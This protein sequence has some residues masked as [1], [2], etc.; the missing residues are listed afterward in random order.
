M[1]VSASS[2][3]SLR[4]TRAGIDT[5][6]QPIAYMHRD[7]E[8]CR[9]EGFVAMT[10]VRIQVGDRFLTATLNVVVNEQIALDEV[11]LSEAAW[12][13]LEPDVDARATVRHPAPAASAGAL[14]AKVF[15][16]RLDDAQ[17][18]TLVEDVV[19]SRLSD[20]ELAAFVSASAGERLDHGETTGLTRAMISV[21]Q[22]LDWGEGTVLDK[23]CVG[24]LPGNRTTPIVV[25]IIA[26]L[27]YLIPKTSSRA[28]TSPAGTADTMEVMA[29]VSLDIPAMRR[30]VE[31]EGGCIVW[32]GN[33]RLSP[34]DDV[35]IRIQRPLDFDSDG[36]LVASVLSKKVAAGS[37]HVLIDMPVGPTA[38]VR[39]DSSADSLAARLRH[40]AEA[41]GLQLGIYRS[42]GTQ[43]VGVG[44]GPALEARDV[45]K[46]LNNDAD[47][48][49]DL[50]ERA[51]A[52][53]G[54]LLELAPGSASGTGI[55]RARAVL[56]SRQAL[57]KFLAICEAQGGFREPPQ[58]ALTA[59][60]AAP[61]E[62]RITAIDNRRLARIAKLAG[63]PTSPAAGLETALRVGNTVQHGQP[64]FTV[65]AQSRGELAYALE[66]ARINQPFSI[67]TEGA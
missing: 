20:L 13:I 36:Q 47:A 33:V 35:L 6:Q 19:E 45:L 64:L 56:H 18:L 27:G 42:D 21:G 14:R 7:C 49:A 62:G 51:I 57:A 22:R 54:A 29:P 63:A 28:I 31:R 53:A 16:A 67:S 40:T 38:K 41:V 30:V 34:A 46:V 15:G 43:P 12:N 9:S 65:H 58:A 3:T 48:P 1:T 26:A 60:V 8:V 4:V 59:D 17:Y 55:Q 52:L 25:A 32:G 37:T 39:S 24:G 66:Y 5:Y 50:K 23:H 11:A 10:R 2:H 61:L 44:I